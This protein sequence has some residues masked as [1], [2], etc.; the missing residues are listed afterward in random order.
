MAAESPTVA[1]THEHST[2]HPE[3]RPTSCSFYHNHVHL[4]ILITCF[5][6][7]LFFSPWLLRHS[8]TLAVP[9]QGFPSVSKPSSD[10]PTQNMCRLAFQLDSVF[11][12]AKFLNDHKSFY[13]QFAFPKMPYA[14]CVIL[15]LRGRARG[16]AVQDQPGFCLGSIQGLGALLAYY[17]WGSGFKAQGHTHP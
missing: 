3:L 5:R 2:G 7:K 13:S 15:A 1:S 17:A 12:C 14:K 8:E 11:W 9:S 4:L 6:A 16:T 10:C